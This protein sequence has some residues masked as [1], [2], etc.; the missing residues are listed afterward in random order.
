MVPFPRRP[1]RRLPREANRAAQSSQPEAKRDPLRELAE[2]M[3]QEEIYDRMKADNI[4]RQ[5]D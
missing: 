4:E 5:R 3:G 1:L 2:M